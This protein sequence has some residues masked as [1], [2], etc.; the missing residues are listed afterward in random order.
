[1]LHKY[2]VFTLNRIRL[3]GCWKVANAM[4]RLGGGLDW[5]LPSSLPSSLPRF[6]Q[7]SGGSLQ[8]ESSLVQASPC[9]HQTKEAGPCSYWTSPVWRVS[10]AEKLPAENLPGQQTRPQARSRP[11]TDQPQT[12]ALTPLW[13]TKTI[14]PHWE[15]NSQKN[16]SN[17]LTTCTPHTPC[18]SPAQKPPN[19]PPKLWKISPAKRIQSFFFFLPPYS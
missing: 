12:D 8:A 6:W 19:F 3:S 9:P 10:Q 2:I 14:F 4:D 13:K 17:F 16:V 11:P 5:S 18:N 1:M 15:R 7:D